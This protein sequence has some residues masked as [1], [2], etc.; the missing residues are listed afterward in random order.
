MPFNIEPTD[1][2]L[3]VLVALLLFGPTKLP[4]IGRGLGKAISEFRNSLTGTSDSIR[5]ELKQPD[6][7]MD[8]GAGASTQ[9][10][11]TFSTNYAK[12]NYCTQC[13]APNPP[14]VRF[15][16]QCGAPFRL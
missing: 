13:G 11:Q 8:T 3:I 6:Q 5:G 14:G 1:L 12:G 16:N 15:C 4:E 9:P 2:I 7:R 10:G